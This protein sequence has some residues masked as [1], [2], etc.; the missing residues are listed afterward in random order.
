MVYGTVDWNVCVTPPVDSH[1]T[2]IETVPPTPG[3]HVPGGVKT[4]VPA[5]CD[6][7]DAATRDAA[8]TYSPDNAHAVAC[9]LAGLA[10]ATIPRATTIAIPMDLNV[11]W[12]SRVIRA[13][14]LQA[15]KPSGLEALRPS[16]LQPEPSPPTIMAEN[17]SLSTTGH[18]AWQFCKRESA[19]AGVNDCV[20]YPWIMRAYELQALTGFDALTRTTRESPPLSHTDVRVRIH[21]AALNYRDLAILRAAHNRVEPVVPLSDGAGEVVAIGAGVTRVA[22]GD[23][24]AASFFPTWIDGELSADA[25]AHALGGAID[26]TL[27]DEV[28]LDQRAWVPL[29]P[30]LSFEEGATLGCAGVTAFNALFNGPCVSAGNTVL[31]LGTG[32]VS[33]FA[34]QLAKAVGARVV[35]TTS[36]QEKASR[37]RALGVDHIINYKET[38]AWGAA[39]REWSHGGVDLVVE[40]GGPGTLDQSIEATRFGGAIS[41]LGVLT[42]VRGDVSLYGIFYKGLRVRGVFV[43]SVKTFDAL[44]TFVTRTHLH[45]VIDRV[46]PFDEARAAYEYLAQA[47]HVGK[48]VI[49]VA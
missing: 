5:N 23:R 25:H 17:R 27:R 6:G 44:T 4:N 9:A 49:K 32:G 30:H 12:V 35:L 33:I 2:L 41:L 8:S 13:P 42:G 10:I 40:V 31:V 19:L 29:P 1:T 11:I 48:V 14:S 28:T 37:A 43:G 22:V 15:S 16:S 24:V 21:A 18:A 7:L 38:P 3:V 26:G 47:G 36:D 34:L 46:F 39:V 45:P 20:Q